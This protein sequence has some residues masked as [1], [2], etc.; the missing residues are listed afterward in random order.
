MSEMS[1]RSIVDVQRGGGVRRALEGD[2]GGVLEGG[3]PHG[4]AGGSKVKFGVLKIIFKSNFGKYV[5]N[6]IANL[7][8]M[9]NEISYTCLT[10]E[11]IPAG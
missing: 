11:P 3:R 2:R 4:A 1:V 7:A 5:Q 8:Q 10:Y 9:R 6:S